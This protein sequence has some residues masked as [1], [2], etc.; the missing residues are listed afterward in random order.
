MRKDETKNIVSFDFDST[1]LKYKYDT[2]YGQVVEGPSEQMIKKLKSYKNKGY[3]VYIVTAR[4][5]W[6][7]Q[8]F[9]YGVSMD[10]PNYNPTPEE[11][12]EQYKL[13][14]DGIY[15]TNNELKVDTLKEL[16]VQIHYD[17]DEEEIEAAKD[18]GINAVQ[19]DIYKEGKD[20]KIDNISHIINEGKFEKE[21]TDMSRFIINELINNIKGNYFLKGSATEENYFAIPEKHYKSIPGI[22]LAAYIVTPDT[23]EVKVPKD[24]ILMSGE[25]I[26]DNG[27]LFVDITLGKDM[28]RWENAK[29]KMSLIVANL[30]D[31]IRHE[32]EHSSQDAK[33]FEKFI[34]VGYESNNEN[35]EE[36]YLDSTEVEA[37]VAGLYKMAKMQK[38]SFIKLINIYLKAIIKPQAQEAKIKD[39]DG[40]L[41]KIKNKWVLYA[42]KRFPR[43]QLSEARTG[44]DPRISIVDQLKPYSDDPYAMLHMSDST[45]VGINVKSAGKFDTP[46]GIY[47]YPIKLMWADISKWSLPYAGERKNVFIAKL[48]KDIK[49]LRFDNYFE[50]SYNEDIK[51]LKSFWE[52]LSLDRKRKVVYAFDANKF[53][54][55][56]KNINEFIDKI[57]N[58][59]SR[60]RDSRL[61]YDAFKIYKL[62]LILAEGGRNTTRWSVIINKI[63]GYDGVYD[64]GLGFIHDNEP[65]Q[66]LVFSSNKFKVKK[67]FKNKQYHVITIM[68]ELFKN[69][70][71]DNHKYMLD[72]FHTFAKLHKFI[73]TIKV[74]KNNRLP[75]EIKHLSKHKEQVWKNIIYFITNILP[76]EKVLIN[77]NKFNFIKH[78]YFS[79][80]LFDNE[81]FLEFL[82]NLYDKDSLYHYLSEQNI[83][84]I[85]KQLLSNNKLKNSDGVFNLL[86]DF[87]LDHNVKVRVKHDIFVD[88]VKL[89]E[90]NNI[91][92]QD[93]IQWLKSKNIIKDK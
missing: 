74:I 55:A 25:Y 28:V 26:P 82:V 56:D 54:L 37:Y 60:H 27:A 52:G 79:E 78:A 14:V 36:Y 16:G 8:N 34:K 51:R 24:T 67:L 31:T 89:I 76:K 62:C 49:L 18:G 1:L 42:K 30:K 4:I 21:T 81:V 61:S 11:F 66:V 73:S 93:L 17:D 70:D 69:H 22:S 20:K 57:I 10:H 12:V 29:E 41:E 33:R 65:E 45:K 88:V 44:E 59:F 13:P 84:E 53:S 75:K 38:R 91:T 48:D 58:E 15:Y 87:Y 43:A 68:S 63:L 23:K 3:K 40:F 39:V 47:F 32:L 90:E 80:K 7:D 6:G 64:P 46:V 50:K 71:L 85:V 77:Y 72:Y 9:N 83:F 5:D 35:I 86:K 19:V 2:D 92:N